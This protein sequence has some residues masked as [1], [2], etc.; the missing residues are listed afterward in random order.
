M[1]RFSGQVAIVTGGARG[2]GAATCVR[3]ARE[4]ASVLVTDV[5]DDE[6]E[7]LAGEIRRAERRAL[8]QHLDVT[9][10]D[11]GG[12]RSIVRRRSDA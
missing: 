6:G 11:T 5:L 8:Y 3:L 1:K 12:A 7:A 9:S 2:I 10:E 4:G